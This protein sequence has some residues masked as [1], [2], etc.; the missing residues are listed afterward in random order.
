MVGNGL[1]DNS[2]NIFVEAAY[3]NVILVDPNK[4]WRIASNGQ[5]VV[6]DRLVDHENLVMFANL[7]AEILPRTKLAIGSSPQDNIRTVSL[8]RINFLKPNDDDFLNTG[9]YDDLTGLGSTEKKARLQRYE[10][11]VDTT[12]GK[13]FYK[14]R[15]QDNL[16]NTIDPGLL[17]ITS[18]ESRTNLSFIPE[19]TIRLED[20]QGRALFELGDQSPYAAFFNLPYPVFYLTMKGYYGQAIR[21]QL[22]LHTFTADFNSQSGNYMVT[23]RFL[24]YKYNILNEIS[25]GHL[26]SVPHMYETAFNF[27]RGIGTQVSNGTTE[28]Q[29]IVDSQNIGEGN[30]SN[31]TI[32]IDTIDARG[33][34]KINEVYSEYIAKKLIPA[35]FPRYTL[36]QLQY[37]LQKIEQT[38]L[39]VYKGK[40]DLQPLTDAEDYRKSLSNYYERIKGGQASWYSEYLDQVPY[41]LQNSDFKVYTFKQN[42]INFIKRGESKLKAIV[43]DGNKSL[44]ENATFGE[45]KGNKNYKIT[46]QITYQTFVVYQPLQIDWRR[47]CVARTGIVNPTPLQVTQFQLQETAKFG[48]RTEVTENGFVEYKQPFFVFDGPGK[49]EN[50]IRDMEGQLNTKQNTIELEISEKLQSVISSPTTGIGFIPNIRNVLAVIMASTEAFIRL[51]NEVHT[52]A[53]DVR[54]D[55]VRQNVILNSSI[56]APNPDNKNN[57]QYALNANQQTATNAEI[58]VY[59]WPQFFVENTDPDRAKYELAYPGDPK[60]V[61]L[62]KGYNYEK[63]PEVEFVEEYLKGVSQRYQPPLATPPQDNENSLT[64]RININAILFPYSNLA[65]LNKNQIK[66]LYEMYERQF[67]YSYYTNFGRLINSPEKS[68]IIGVVGTTEAQNIVQSL[69]V[70]NPYLIQILKNTPL[71]PTTFP[72]VLRN[73]SLDGQGRLWQTYIRGDFTTEYLRNSVE[74]PNGLL[75]IEIFNTGYQNAN[76]DNPVLSSL[77]SLSVYVDEPQLQTIQEMLSS[78]ITNTPQLTDLYPYTVETWDQ[79]NMVGFLLVSG[80]DNIFNTTRTYKFYTPTKTITNF[81]EPTNKT[82]IRPVTSFNYIATQSPDL[83]SGLSQLYTNRTLLLPTEGVYR[84][85]PSSNLLLRNQLDFDTTT[86][87]LNTPYFINSILYGVEQDKSGVSYPYKQAAFLFLNSLPLATLR[88]KYKSLGPGGQTVSLDYIFA[89]F[90]KFGAIHRIPFVWILKYGA[91]WHRYK[92][93]VELNQ[94]ILS[95]IWGNFDYARQYDPTSTTPNTSKTYNLGSISITLQ[96]ST[97]VNNTRTIEMDLGFYPKTIN[98][99]NYFLNGNNLFTNYSDVEIQQAVTNGM[100]V[101][102]LSQ[103]NITTNTIDSNGLPTTVDLSTYSIVIPDTIPESDPTAKSCTVTPK[104]PQT[105]YYILPSF[106]SNQNEV[107][108][109]CFSS[110]NVLTE[111]LYNNDS[112]FNGSVRTF[113]KLPNYGYFNTTD[114]VRPNYQG[115]F[116]TPRTNG[117]QAFEFSNSDDYLIFE[118]VFTTLEKSVLDLMESEFLNFSQSSTKFTDTFTTA[119]SV[120]VGLETFGVDGTQNMNFRNFQLLF[121]DLMSVP[122][123]TT[124]NSQQRITEMIDLQYSQAI[125]KIQNL[126]DFDVILKLGNPGNYDRR[127]WASYVQHITNVPQITEPI[128]WSPFVTGATPTQSLFIYFGNSTIP[129][130]NFTTQGNYIID[131]F[132]Q[133]NI[134]LSSQNVAQLNWL[135]KMYT[136]QKIENNSLTIQ[137]FAGQISAWVQDHTLFFNDTLNLTNTLIKKPDTGLPDVTE[138]PENVI[139]SQ[140]DGSQTK[141]ELYEM[142]KALNDKWIAGYDDTRTLF[143]DVLFLDRASRNVGDKVIIDI[144]NLQQMTDPTHLNQKMSVF[145][146]I[147]GI[148]T[149]NHFSVMPVPAYVNF[150]NVQN[151]PAPST[152]TIQPSQEFANEM[153]GT[154]MTVDTRN[155]GP[156]LVC[157]YTDR[158]SSYLDMKDNKNYLFRSDSFDLRNEQLNPFYEDFSQKTDWALSN[159]VVGFNVDIGV[160]NQNIFYSFSISQNN[161]KATSESIQQ[162]NLMANSATGRNTATQN[163]SLYN[164]YKNMSYE[165]EVV[166]FGNALLQPTMYFNLRHV[167]MFNGSYMITQ[168]E[169]SIQPGQFITKF[170]GIRQSYMS[171]PRI[172]VYLQSIKSN[173]VSKLL[174]QYRN[175]KDNPTQTASTTTQGDNANQSVQSN[176]QLA[177]QNSCDSKVVFPYLEPD[178]AY[179][180]VPGTT[181]V[182]SPQKFYEEIRKVEQRDDVVFGI[183]VI[184]WMSTGIDKKFKGYNYNFG[185]VLLTN[186]YGPLGEKYFDKTYTCQVA[187]TEKDSKVTLPYVGFANIQDYILFVRDKIAPNIPRIKSSGLIP[188]YLQNWPYTKN[189]NQSSSSILAQSYTEALVLLNNVTPP[190]TKPLLPAVP[191]PQPTKNLGNIV[192]ATPPCPT[193]TASPVIVRGQGSG[194]GNPIPTQTPSPSTS[195]PKPTTNDDAILSNAELLQTSFILRVDYLGFLSTTDFLRG[196]FT[197]PI[198]SQEYPAKLT[199]VA[200]G[201]LSGIP[202]ADFTISPNTTNTRGEFKSKNNGWKDVLS[203]ISTNSEYYS[204]YFVV[205]VTTPKQTYK[206]TSVF[207]IIPFDCPK[208]DYRRDDIIDV[209]D[210]EIILDNPCCECYPNGTNSSRPF[211]LPKLKSTNPYTLE[212]VECKITGSNC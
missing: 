20:V 211:K 107:K 164:I 29:V 86:S 90:K 25:M 120:G 202:V 36:A 16:G 193:P 61:N 89:S 155:S 144:F 150:Y 118:E 56:T 183:F 173:L 124:T 195:S 45:L 109:K 104:T 14:Q 108:F 18:I 181:Y 48:I 23:C 169:H 75:P 83:T 81:L 98:S 95:P 140:W 160:R 128:Q 171:L 65:Y 121:R 35:D 84:N 122:L 172:D 196:T 73:S 37:K 110:T 97:F 17:G 19:V 204:V 32:S 74:H 126:M 143:E 180:A 4:T 142:F 154:Y 94:D 146:F 212:S 8:A 206:F 9:Y 54:R 21:Y 91:L 52:K 185:K 2:G 102:N 39:D 53:W 93:Q 5:Q 138:V 7:E 141:V 135:V 27:S 132:V 42:E 129:Q 87:M 133:S 40:A 101:V 166:S 92:T 34:Q 161:G 33:L 179:Q 15:F 210:M 163:V 79:T 145:T 182:L 13:K 184:S 50:L 159:R 147:S 205:N 209:P 103:S 165:C 153:W 117:T 137:E 192:T 194:T 176:N 59:P 46:N 72:E 207:S 77:A 136:T 85:T 22:N 64:R 82:E 177:A 152:V 44:D 24:G 71:T 151:S 178:W 187:T 51:M 30:Q 28:T 60:I 100:Q 49:F 68:D 6:E 69:G 67:I 190:I 188:Y 191:I 12:D 116:T 55:P 127:L 41:Y 115:Y 26:V 148:L 199:V 130:A 139:Q 70:S 168:V 62:T 197:L 1:S 11:L 170:T 80:Q 112:V 96:K 175:A 78:T 125:S 105:N 47:S 203:E 189:V 106:G 156:K 157:F 162:I 63:W 38:I 113:W 57:V 111:P 134:E 198:L 167:P 66:Y 3:N 76:V 149:Q 201:L 208:L 158:P 123:P 200:N 58:D 43:I 99:F 174:Q 88:E 119:S 114:I 186:D 131:F 31:S 10:D